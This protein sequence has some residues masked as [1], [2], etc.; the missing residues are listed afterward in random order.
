[1]TQENLLVKRLMIT[2]TGECLLKYKV[3]TLKVGKDK[4]VDIPDGCIPI[5]YDCSLEKRD[6]IV[7]LVMRVTVL[8]PIVEEKHKEEKC[9]FCNENFTI[10][11]I[12]IRP[13]CA[14]CLGELYGMARESHKLEEC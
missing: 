13:I 6:P 4:S 9:F 8:M 7:S 2:G 10:D 1:M 5:K 12:G 11:K 3:E 14:I